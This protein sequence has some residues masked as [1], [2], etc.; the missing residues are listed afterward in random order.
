MEDQRY[1]HTNISTS[2]RLFNPVYEQLRE[3]NFESAEEYRK[4]VLMTPLTATGAK[5]RYV[6]LENTRYLIWN[7]SQ[8]SLHLPRHFDFTS[9]TYLTWVSI[10]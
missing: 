1:S 2:M 10:Q 7:L 8:M 4:P 6:L 5:D 9:I 3:K